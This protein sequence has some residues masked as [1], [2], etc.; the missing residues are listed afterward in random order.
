MA[1]LQRMLAF[2]VLIGRN[3]IPRLESVVADPG[4]F[5]PNLVLV[6]VGP[7]IGLSVASRFAADGYDVGLIARSP[8]TLAGL[9]ERLSTHP[10]RVRARVADAGDEEQLGTA[11]DGLLH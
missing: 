1:G 6:G 4:G 11:L 10:V 7:G 2:R 9:T 8:S 3:L 5:M